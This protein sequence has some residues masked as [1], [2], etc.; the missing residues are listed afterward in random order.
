[1]R[2]LRIHACALLAAVLLP[3]CAAPAGAAPGPGA[4]TLEPAIDC[5]TGPGR[6]N[7]VVLLGGFGG[8]GDIGATLEKQLSGITTGIR[9]AGGCPLIFGYGIIGP[10]H[11][12]APVPESARQVA[13]FVDKVLATTGAARVD[14][15]AHSSGALVADYYVK[16]L[17]GDSHVRRMVQL[18][19]VTRG[20]T[21]A[22]LVAGLGIPGVPGGPAELIQDAANPWRD[23]V[24]A[25][26]RGA[27]DCLAGS[28]VT[29]E[30]LAGGV[31]RPGVR[32][33]VLATRGDQV[34]TPPGTASFIEEPGVLNEFFEDRYPDAG[35]AGHA[36]LPMQPDADRWVLDQLFSN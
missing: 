4:G 35:V 26:L 24:F 19:P 5:A 27:L 28:E 11:A 6:P 18:A 10:V 8:V 16:L 14:I 34:L 36:T 23:T 20:T 22:T 9:A 15:V 13:A 33:A 29:R 32:Y 2:E 31:T 7:P 30:V 17:H 12:A 21:G 3:L 1:M 25:G